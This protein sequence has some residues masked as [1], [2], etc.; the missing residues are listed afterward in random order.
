MKKKPRSNK[1]KS[2]KGKKHTLKRLSFWP[3]K[4]E[5]ALEAFFRVDLGK[6]LGRIVTTG[7]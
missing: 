4:P 3:L 6:V 7:P 1:K 5:E 2:T